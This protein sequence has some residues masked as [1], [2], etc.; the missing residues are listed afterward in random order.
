MSKDKYI[1][2]QI[3]WFEPDDRR[4][5][6][7]YTMIT[8]VGRVYYTTEYWDLKFDKETLHRCEYPHGRLYASEQE[9]KDYKKAE[10]MFYSL[11]N[12]YGL[13]PTLEQMEAIYKILGLEVKE[14][15]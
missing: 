1:V 12:K 6:G 10:S 11:K 3:V 2:G 5:K 15:E 4:D 7:R 13:K 14:D 9:A 8:K